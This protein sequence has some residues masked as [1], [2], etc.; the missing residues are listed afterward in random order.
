MPSNLILKAELKGPNVLMSKKLEEVVYFSMQGLNLDYTNS[1]VSQ[2]VNPA[3]GTWQIDN[4]LQDTFFPVLLQPTPISKEARSLGALPTVQ[5]SVILLNDR[6]IFE[7][8][9]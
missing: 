8:L 6:G 4:Q 3:I 9:Y 2:S 1:L 5:A 7:E